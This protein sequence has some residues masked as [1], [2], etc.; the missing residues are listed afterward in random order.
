MDEFFMRVL[1]QAISNSISRGYG[2]P[3][4]VRPLLRLPPVSLFPGQTP[5]QEVSSPH[6]VSA[7]ALL[8]H[9]RA[10]RRA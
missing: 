3:L 6:A 8:L 2:L 9:H 4:V 5:A 10:N 7:A 1:A